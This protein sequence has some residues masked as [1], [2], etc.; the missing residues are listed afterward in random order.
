MTF[1]RGWCAVKGSGSFLAHPRACCIL[2]SVSLH[3]YCPEWSASCLAQP[4][5]FP[6]SV[7]E[8][9]FADL[10]LSAKLPY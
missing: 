6:S 1:Q 9:L 7:W 3:S 10:A 4:S 5:W 2:G 8:G